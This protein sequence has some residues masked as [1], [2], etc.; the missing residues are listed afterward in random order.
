[1]LI[2][3][4]I[5]GYLLTFV[6]NF[7]MVFAYLQR[8]K[9]EDDSCKHLPITKDDCCHAL[10]TSLPGPFGILSIFG[11]CNFFK[12]G[13]KITPGECNGKWSY[14]YDKRMLVT[15]SNSSGL[16]KSIWKNM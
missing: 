4:L 6:L 16:Y 5:T 7:G 1:M 2:I 9:L 10:I 15:P 8:S 14:I 3:L 12:Y 13:W 11:S